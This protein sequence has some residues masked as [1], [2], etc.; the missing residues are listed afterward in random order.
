M[1]MAKKKKRGARK[2]TLPIA[3]IA[4][5]LAAPAIRAGAKAAIAGDID[6]VMYEAGKF[7]GFTDGKFDAF[8]LGSN[9][10][11]IIIG[12]LVHKFVGGPPLNVNRML[13][14]ANVPVIRI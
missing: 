7:V 5:L 14:A 13:A 12:I 6:G 8:A 3:P 1:K 2:F 11:P 4:G 9:I 10:L